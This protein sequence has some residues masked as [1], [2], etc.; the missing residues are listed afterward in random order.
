[1]KHRTNFVIFGKFIS[2]WSFS[3]NDIF[4]V[5]VSC[6]W[7]ISTT[8]WTGFP[9]I[10]FV[11]AVYLCESGFSALPHIKT[12]TRNQSEVKRDKR[13][14]VKHLT[15]NFEVGHTV[16]FCGEKCCGS[17]FHFSRTAF[18]CN[19]NGYNVICTG[20]KDRVRRGYN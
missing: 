13:C 12:E 20:I 17:L 5:L 4:S 10:A 16:N 2:T 19:H 7:I 3:W 18:C 1:M 6:A 9:N 11:A 8:V 15:T 14:Q